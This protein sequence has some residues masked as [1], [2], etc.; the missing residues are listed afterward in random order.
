MSPSPDSSPA[1]GQLS[2]APDAIHV[3]LAAVEQPAP[4]MI[5]RWRELL[6]E[7]ELAREAAFVRQRDRTLF[8]SD[9]KCDEACE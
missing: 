4:Q 8:A 1:G 3:W 2:L 7:E 5:D 9:G 6:D